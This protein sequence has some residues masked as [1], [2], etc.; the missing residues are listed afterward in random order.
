[1]SESTG[2]NEGG[3]VADWSRNAALLVLAFVTAC[4]GE[5]RADTGPGDTASMASATADT[6]R[7]GLTP[8]PATT[9]P[10]TAARPP[11][12]IDSAPTT[13]APAAGARQT[14]ADTPRDATPKP[15]PTA[16]P[17]DTRTAPAAAAAP[18]RD[19][20]P[21]PAQVAQLPAP[22][23][24]Q[25]T[26]T[27]DAP[28]RDEYHQAPKDTVEQ[29]V[30]D[31]W[32]QYNLNCARCHGEDVLGST[33]APHLITSVKPNGPIN[34]QEAFIQVV[35]AGRPELGMPAWCPL[36]MEMEKINQIY[37]YVKGRSDGEIGP[38]R[39]ALRQ[40]G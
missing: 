4:G 18:A 25:A 39:P 38:G 17:R 14:T 3:A 32:K 9:S 36:G 40:G 6:A 22:A 34:T 13:Q 27:Q 21:T 28:L 19:T 31:G 26:A 8:D 35:C 7:A 30:Y 12:G 37:S 16:P 33:I 2:R 1:M 15:A 5:R 20:A 10:D 29:A 24:P 11:A 23:A